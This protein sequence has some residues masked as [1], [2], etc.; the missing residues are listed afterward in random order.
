L[1]PRLR[2]SCPLSSSTECKTFEKLSTVESRSCRIRWLALHCSW[3][4]FTIDTSFGKTVFAAFESSRILPSIASN[5]FLIGLGLRFIGCANSWNS[6]FVENGSGVVN[7]SD[8]RRPKLISR[9]ARFRSPGPTKLA[10]NR[11]PTDLKRPP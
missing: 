4:D 6:S 1:Y 3:C 11:E 5:V 8:D 7:M 10:T 9:G 2:K